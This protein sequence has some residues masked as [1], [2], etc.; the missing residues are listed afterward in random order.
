M[1]W[2]SDLFKDLG[3][4]FQVGGA[5]SDVFGAYASARTSQARERANRN[6]NEAQAKVEE[7][8]AQLA[9]WQAQDALYRG[10]VEENRTRLNTAAMKSTQRARMAA[11]GIMLDGD[12]AVRTL[13]DTDV[14]GEI[15]AMT[16]R[17]NAEREAWALRQQAQDHRNRA[18]FSREGFVQPG[19]STSSAV[20]GSLLSG[21]GRVAR[22]W[23]EWSR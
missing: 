19:Q 2:A 14:L 17:T 18:K 9:T 23:Y 13:T 5:I 10:Q 21:S 12:S 16:N 1:S 4:G 7:N 8:N 15:D 22:S 11:N 20:I 6:A 3:F